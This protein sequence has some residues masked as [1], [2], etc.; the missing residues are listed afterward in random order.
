V[1]QLLGRYGVGL[2]LADAGEDIGRLVHT[3]GDERSELLHRAVDTAAATMTHTVQ[4]AI[5]LFSARAATRED[6]R[7]AC[8]ALAGVFE[9]RRD[10][11]K[12]ELLS[13]DEGALFEIANKF[14]VRHRWADQHGDYDEAYLDWL[15]WW[16]LTTIELTNRLLARPSS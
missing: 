3:S 15:F 11:V 13:K 6:K 14:N 12:T 7:S 8:I 1:N 4:H 10:L 5:A 9:A 2:E 16:Y